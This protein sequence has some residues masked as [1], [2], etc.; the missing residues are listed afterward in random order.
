MN[1][2]A[3]IR[4]IMGGIDRQEPCTGCGR[5]VMFVS[6]VPSRWRKRIIANVYAGERWDRVE[7]WHIVCYAR[8]ELP[9]GAPEGINR[10]DLEQLVDIATSHPTWNERLILIALA[11]RYRKAGMRV[12]SLGVEFDS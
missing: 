11:E 12:H 6:Q 4:P 2:R 9:H 1:T 5:A 7:I 8:N 3:V 10:S